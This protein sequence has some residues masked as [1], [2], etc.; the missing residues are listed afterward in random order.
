MKAPGV[1]TIVLLCMCIVIVVLY[2]IN[3]AANAKRPLRMRRGSRED[4]RSSP[5][6]PIS[7]SS[8][9][10]YN[11]FDSGKLPKRVHFDNRADDFGEQSTIAVGAATKYQ[12]V[13]KLIEV[14]A[15]G[16]ILGGD[17]SDPRGEEMYFGNLVSEAQRMDQVTDN[18]SLS[19]VM[20]SSWRADDTADTGVLDEYFSSWGP[21]TSDDGVDAL[22]MAASG[23]S[24]ERTVA[25]II[26][27]PKV[28]RMTQ[29]RPTTSKLGVDETIGIR[30]PR[31]LPLMVTAVQV[32]ND[33]DQ[34]QGMIAQMHGGIY[35]DAN[36]NLV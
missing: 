28:D 20:P 9:E 35:P 19:A 10:L 6:R 5:R 27:M 24:R 2:L 31:K 21:S 32:F 16:Q 18:M 29:L 26:N 25:A 34:R 23:L 30:A 14:A 12:E 17:T 3:G 8:A 1:L 33:S 15:V 7:V 11:D 13:E 4:R 36:L 22:K